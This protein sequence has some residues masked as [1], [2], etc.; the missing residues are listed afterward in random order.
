MSLALELGTFASDLRASNIP[1]AIMA[2]ARTALLNGYGIGLG[3]LQTPYGALAADAAFAMDGELAEGGATLLA[4]GGRSSVAGA[5]FANAVLFH[6]RAQEDTCGSS[7]IGAVVIPALGALVEA[8]QAD[9]ADFLPALVAGYEVGGLLDRA[10]A[11]ASTPRGNRGS[12]IY[13]SLGAA[14]AVA[15]LLR[16]DGERT[17]AAIANVCA[18][19]GG[20]LQSLGEGTDEWRYQLGSATRGGIAAAMLARAGSIS[21]PAALE[22]PTGFA[23]AFAGVSLDPGIASELGQTWSLDRVQFKPHPVCVFNQSPVI[24]ALAL[25]ERIAGRAID[26]FAITMNPYEAGYAGMA[27]SGPFGNIGATLMSGRFCVATALLRGAPSLDLLTTYD[28]PEV[29]RLVSRSTLTADAGLPAISCEIT[30]KL[31]DGSSER[32]RYIATPADYVFSRAQVFEMIQRVVA[33]LGIGATVVERLDQWV[34]ALPN[35]SIGDVVDL[36]A[37]ARDEA[38]QCPIAPAM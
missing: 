14:A 2:R 4:N 26:S 9:I 29:L 13:G 16:L 28:D 10:L 21:A 20:T 12:V 32:E 3:S 34:D 1:P 18:F 23:R 17:A 25:R 7:H 19:T 31:A 27:S 5:A 33:E 38:G 36:F 35:A 22:G 30:V 8:G 24:A 15:R 11:S 6:G 37:A